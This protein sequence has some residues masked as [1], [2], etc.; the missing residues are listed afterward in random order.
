[1][2]IASIIGS[3]TLFL[4]CLILLVGG[5]FQL[6]PVETA[7]LT[8]FGPYDGQ[9]IALFC[10]LLVITLGSIAWAMERLFERAGKAGLYVRWRMNRQANA[11]DA[12]NVHE[13]HS[14]S[15]SP[16]DRKSVV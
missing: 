6:W 4:L 10:A 9:G 15:A 14:D 3:V 8:G 12:G 5:I 2:K 11:D 16:P 7:R 1:M 13:F